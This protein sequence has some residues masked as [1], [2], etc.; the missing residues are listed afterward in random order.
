MIDIELVI[1]DMQFVKVLL[2]R[3][4]NFS[5]YF[6]LVTFY[7]NCELLG[8]LM[9][10][11][12]VVVEVRLG[13]VGV[14]VFHSLSLCLEVYMM[15]TV[16]FDTHPLLLQIFFVGYEPRILL[17]LSFS[18]FLRLLGN[19]SGSYFHRSRLSSP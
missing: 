10:M 14:P 5:K 13:V 9:F 8:W 3:I 17:Y 16:C 6:C 15:S 18:S 11:Q 2:W 1:A 12:V 7:V 4:C 19:L